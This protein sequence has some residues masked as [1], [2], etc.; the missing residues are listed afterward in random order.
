MNNKDIKIPFNS[1]LKFAC[2]LRRVPI[3]GTNQYTFWL[4]FKGAPEQII[5][6]C[7]TYLLNGQEKKMDKKFQEEFDKANKAF[8]KLYIIMFSS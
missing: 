6:R 5:K 1:K 7:S 2:Y 4:A 8:G 3:P